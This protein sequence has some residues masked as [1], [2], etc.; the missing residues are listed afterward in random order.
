M[1]ISLVLCFSIASTAILYILMD[2]YAF[3]SLEEQA[4]RL[5]QREKKQVEDIK[6]HNKQIAKKR[7]QLVLEPD[8]TCASC[9]SIFKPN[10]MVVVLKCKMEH[11]YHISCLE[12][13]IDSNNKGCSACNKELN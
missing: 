13:Q 11:A 2:F 3:K 9:N 8:Q 1:I 4:M 7:T 5:V 12:Q 6:M 10:D